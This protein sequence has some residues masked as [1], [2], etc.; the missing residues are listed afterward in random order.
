MAQV[1]GHLP[2]N[3]EAMS[4]NPTLVCFDYLVSSLG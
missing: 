4:S 2:S 3:C 1:V